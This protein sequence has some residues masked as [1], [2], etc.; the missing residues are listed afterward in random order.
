MLFI[1]IIYISIPVHFQVRR[2]CH[3]R[4]THTKNIVYNSDVRTKVRMP[5]ILNVVVGESRIWTPD[6]T[7]RIL[8]PHNQCIDM[9]P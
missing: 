8:K 6:L 5:S 1:Y 7:R 4:N 2:N 9:A 3:Q